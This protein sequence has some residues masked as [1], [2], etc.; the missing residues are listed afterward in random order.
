MKVTF[1]ALGAWEANNNAT[2]DYELVCLWDT[3]P[4]PECKTTATSPLTIEAAVP[5]GFDI[6]N[7]EY[8]LT[9]ST[10]DSDSAN[11]F[12]KDGFKPTTTPVG[13]KPG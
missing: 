7:N 12:K 5:P 1:P 8:I 11:P 2:K 13:A 4:S 3:T 10:R 6:T 9:L